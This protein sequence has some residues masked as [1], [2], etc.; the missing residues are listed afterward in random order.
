MYDSVLIIQHALVTDFIQKAKKKMPPTKK[1]ATQKDF[2]TPASSNETDGGDGKSFPPA[3][4]DGAATGGGKENKTSS[5]DS[6]SV[7]AGTAAVKRGEVSSSNQ[8]A[9]A[10]RLFEATLG[11]LQSASRAKNYAAEARANRKLLR[12]SVGP[13]STLPAILFPSR[14]LTNG[15]RAVEMICGV[16]L[17]NLKKI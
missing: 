2:K 17:G 16:I 8:Q 14:N 6:K 15:G 7:G 5:S 11:E 1:L 10:A 12:H 9:A 4:K 3:N 13:I